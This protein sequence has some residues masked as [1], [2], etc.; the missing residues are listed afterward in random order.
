VP[1]DRR[2]VVPPPS[3]RPMRPH[4]LL[5]LV[6]VAARPRARRRLGASCRVQLRTGRGLVLE[7]RR[8]RVRVR[9]GARSPGA[10]PARPAGPGPARAGA[11]RLADAP[12][13]ATIVTPFADPSRNGGYRGVD[14]RRA[15]RALREEEPGPG[16]RQGHSAVRAMPSAAPVDHRRR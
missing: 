9:T 2:L 12:A 7:L 16:G 1:G 8:F 3:L 10:P 14:G 15:V 13:L 5:R 6:A 11:V 4:R